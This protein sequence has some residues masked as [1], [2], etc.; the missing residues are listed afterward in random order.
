[1]FYSLLLLVVEE[2]QPAS[3]LSLCCSS[4]C[5][6]LF[7]CVYLFIQSLFATGLTVFG[8]K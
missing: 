4:F 2:E 6:E 7:L 8:A 1:M 3:I 5:F